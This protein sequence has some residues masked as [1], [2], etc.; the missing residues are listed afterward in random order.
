MDRM[1]HFFVSAVNNTKM[2]LS[3]RAHYF[4]GKISSFGS[5]MRKNAIDTSVYTKTGCRILG[6]ECRTNQTQ[7]ELNT[8]IHT[9]HIRQE[10]EKRL[11]AIAAA[12]A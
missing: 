12:I 1:D 3:T 5:G 6:V 7:S 8:H 4:D 11:S 10:T 9:Q 2:D